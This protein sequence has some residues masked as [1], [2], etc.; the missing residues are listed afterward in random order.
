MR[1][2]SRRPASWEN[3]MPEGEV[4]R[5]EDRDPHHLESSKKAQPKVTELCK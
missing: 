4:G 3:Y 1:L 2:Q 5:Q